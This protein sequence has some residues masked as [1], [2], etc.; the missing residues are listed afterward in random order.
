MRYRVENLGTEVKGTN[1]YL[2]GTNFLKLKK[3]FPKLFFFLIP[4]S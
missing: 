4:K 1:V 2:Y 3:S